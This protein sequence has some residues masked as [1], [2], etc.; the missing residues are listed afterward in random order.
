MH[1]LCLCRPSLPFLFRAPPSFQK[2]HLFAG[3]GHVYVLTRNRT[4]HYP[5]LVS[6]SSSLLLFTDSFLLCVFHGTADGSFVE[7]SS[8][9][10]ARELKKRYDR[11][12][13]IDRDNRSPYA[14]TAFV[15][16][17]GKQMYRVGY[18]GL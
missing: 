5:Q 17:H 8:G 11:F 12:I 6:F 3:F 10:A 7:T 4:I 1:F 16:Q 15:N 18:V 2:N 9:Q 14:I 13:K